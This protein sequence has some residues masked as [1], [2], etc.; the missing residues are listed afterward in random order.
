MCYLS[1]DLHNT[2]FGISHHPKI[3]VDSAKFNSD[4]HFVKSTTII[5]K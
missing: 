3:M 5:R 4:S 1:K 2:G